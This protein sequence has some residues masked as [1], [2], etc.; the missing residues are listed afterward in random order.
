MWIRKGE[1]PK[2]I[3]RKKNAT[4]K[5]VVVELVKNKIIK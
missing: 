2:E 5:L 4:M 1:S 3:L